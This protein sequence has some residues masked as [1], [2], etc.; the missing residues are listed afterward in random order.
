MGRLVVLRGTLKNFHK[1]RV[2]GDF[3]LSNL[4]W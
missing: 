3:L 1:D 2:I 4:E